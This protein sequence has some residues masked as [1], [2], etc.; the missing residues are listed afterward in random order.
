MSISESS[1]EEMPLPT[2]LLKKHTFDYEESEEEDDEEIQSE[3]TQKE[4]HQTRK[5]TLLLS[6]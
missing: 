3:P 4:V 6:I 1:S 2:F 5:G